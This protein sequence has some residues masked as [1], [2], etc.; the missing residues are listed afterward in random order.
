MVAVGIN[1]L[2]Q[3]ALFY[4][5]ISTI[6]IIVMS[7]QN[8]GSKPVY[9]LGQYTCDVPSVN[10]VFLIKIVYVLF[11]T[12]ILNIICR[13]GYSS[14]SWFLVFIPFIMMFIVIAYTFFLDLNI[15]SN[16]NNYSG[17]TTVSNYF[18]TPSQSYNAINNW[19]YY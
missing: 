5:L 8:L 9:C 3:P 1:N 15:Y 11:W 19:L 14:I 7:L 12:W 13:Y 4:L 17:Y 18:S 16:I 6:A 10:Y 2:C